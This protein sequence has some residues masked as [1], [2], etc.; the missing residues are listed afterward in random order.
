MSARQLRGM[1]ALGSSCTLELHSVFT[2]YSLHRCYGST[3]WLLLL[4][5]YFFPLPKTCL[6]CYRGGLQAFQL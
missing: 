1:G 6:C 5:W 3:S 4:A 2:G